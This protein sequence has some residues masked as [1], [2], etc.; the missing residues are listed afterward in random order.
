MLDEL[1]VPEHITEKLV[2]KY[3]EYITEPREFVV[4]RHEIGDAQ[5]FDLRMWVGEPYGDYAIGWSIVGFSKDDPADI[6][7]WIENI[8]KGFRA[9][10][11]CVSEFCN[12]WKFEIYEKDGKYYYKLK[13]KSELS[14]EELAR[15]PYAWF[16]PKLKVGDSLEIEPGEVGAGEEAPGRFTILTRGKWMS[17]TQKAYFHEYFLKD[18]RY[19]KDWTRVVLRAVKVAKID[20]ETKKP[21]KGKYERMWRF[22]I[23]KTQMPYAISNRAMKENWKPPKECPFPFPKEWVKENFENQY[24][25][26]LQWITK[27]DEE[28]INKLEKLYT[29]KIDEF[30]SKNVRFSLAL[31]SWMGARAKTGRQMPQFRWY[32]FI[33]DG[34]ERVRTFFLDGYP[35]RDEIMGAFEMDRSGKK[36]MEYDGKVGPDTKFNENKRMAADFTTVDS[37]TAKYSIEKSETGEEIVTIEFKGKK[38]RGRWQLIQED[39]DTDTYTFEKLSELQERVAKFVLDKHWFPEDDPNYHYDLRWKLEDSNYLEEINL[40]GNP[41]E[42]KIEEPIKAVYKTCSTDIDE[43]MSVKEPG[44]RMKA[45]GVWSKVETIDNGKLTILET[46]PNFISMNI[47]GKKLKGYFILKR[48][49]NGWVFMRSKLPSSEMSRVFEMMELYYQLL[50]AGDPR[51]GEPFDPF[52]IEEKRGWDHFIVHIYDLRKFTRVEPSEKVKKYLPDLE[53]PEG[54]DIAIGLYPV[55]GRIHHARVAYVTFKSDKWDYDKAVEWIKRNKLHEFVR[56]QIREKRK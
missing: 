3:M 40:Y 32:L 15:Q 46:S 51:T 38:L 14:L 45:Y 20:P 8:G 26:W 31:V 54:V 18:G 52:Q 19:F 12:E 6:K 50:A 30:L 49:G 5:H 10:T 41:I 25:K 2:A 53:I 39:P 29:S 47:D 33:D 44:T 9:E 13:S 21:I 4:E 42:A 36:W 22:M 56:T 34:K 24:R 1:A 11:K 35:L 16:F 48:A 55:P 17:G 43:W 28:D 23:P 7:K 27:S 37:G